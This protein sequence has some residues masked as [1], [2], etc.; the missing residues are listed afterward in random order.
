MKKLLLLALLGTLPM[1]AKSYATDF[2]E[3]KAG[4]LPKDWK[5]EMTGSKN[6]EGIWQIEKEGEDQI[7]RLKGFKRKNRATY[8][9]CYT[10]GV[11]F[12]D[13]EISV[14]FRADSGK[15]DQGGGIM[16]RVQDRDNYYVAR[17]NPLEDNFRFYVVKNGSRHQLCSADN[18]HL[19]KGW[20]E[21]K[22]AQKGAHFI[23]Y[24][25]GKKL[26]ECEDKS[27]TQSGGVGLWTKSD[28]ATSFDTF[29]IEW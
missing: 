28:A 20:H 5:S 14:R 12:K 4:A 23:G 10:N 9:L 17:F 15:E 27:L 16:W 24:L 26:L 21:M 13:G 1:M 22:I 6:A 25:D 8:N 18:I 11:N 3:D 2:E 19:K 7:L 29:K